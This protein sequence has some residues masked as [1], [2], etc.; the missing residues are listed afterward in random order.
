M[1]VFLITFIVMVLAV[2]AMAV[3]VMMGRREL[4]GSC[5]GLGN[6]DGAQCPCGGPQNCENSTQPTR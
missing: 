2:L 6:V 1:S 5:G 4:K 3:G